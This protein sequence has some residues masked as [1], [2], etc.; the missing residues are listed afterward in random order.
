MLVV[1]PV[2]KLLQGVSLAGLKR[3]LVLVLRLRVEVGDGV[4]SRTEGGV[5]G[6]LH[7]FQPRGLRSPLFRFISAG[8]A[9]ASP[10]PLSLSSV[11]LR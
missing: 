11:F 10:L 4:C 6:P 3:D 5:E 2:K 7:I 9:S 8:P 1:N